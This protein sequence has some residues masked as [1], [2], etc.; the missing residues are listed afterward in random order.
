MPRQVLTLQVGQCGNQI[1]FEFWKQLCLEHGIGRDGRLEPY[2]IQGVDR[3]DCFFYEADDTRYVPR[4]LL[5]DLEPRV[6]QSVKNSSFGPLFNPENFFL[7][8]RDRG[9]AG[10]NWA[11]GYSQG[12]ALDEL[13][14][15]MIDREAEN[16]DSLAGFQLCHSIAGGTGSGLG[17]YLM[18]Q[19]RDRYPKQV[20]Q[21]YSIFPNQSYGL[22]SGERHADAREHGNGGGLNTGLS[23][24]DEDDDMNALLSDVVVQPY[25]SLLTLRRLVECADCVTVLD[26]TAL[27]RIASE[28]LYVENPSFDQANALVSMVMAA[29]TTTMRFPAYTHH[30]LL[31]IV[32][33]LVPLPSCHFVVASCTPL[34]IYTGNRADSG[35]PKTLGAGLETRST[36]ALQQVLPVAESR[37]RKTSVFDV[38]RRLVQPKSLMANCS[39]RRGSYLSLLSI[40]QGE[41]EDPSQLHRSLQRLFEREHF[42]FTPLT[43]ANMQVTS[44]RKSPYLKSTHRVSGLLLANHTSIATLVGRTISA[45]DKLRRRNAFLDNYCREPP[46]AENLDEFDLARETAQH[47]HDVYSELEQAQASP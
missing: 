43:S 23:P 6:I 42:K 44:A 18:E 11:S 33:A 2:A 25:N 36:D 22:G 47:L 7:D 10:N 9:G 27:N 30:D 29:S 38:M 26:N 40:I 32:S 39:L 28:R 21:T 19:L 1:G 20:L 41:I 35:S 13:L 4:A 12:Q 17:S 14:F 24:T 46:F 34:T 5:I 16:A 3:K 37:I 45:Y 8:I 15:D 31:G